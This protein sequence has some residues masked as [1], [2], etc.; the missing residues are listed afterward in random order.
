MEGS[1]QAQ[2]EEALLLR[3]LTELAGRAG[4]R[5]CFLFTEFLGLPEQAALHIAEKNF[6]GG[7][8]YRLFGGADGCE[9]QMARFGDPEELGYEEDFPITLLKISPKEEK[10]AEA[11]T[12]RDYLGALMN[13]GI[14]RDR[15][16]DIVIRGKTAYLFCTEEIAPHLAESLS[17]VRRTDV[18]CSVADSLPEG[19][20]YRTKPVTVQLSGERID[21]VVAKVFSLSRE[22]AQALFKRGLVFS[23]GR[24]VSNDSAAPKPGAVISVRGYGRM[25]YRGIASLSRKGKLNVLVEVYV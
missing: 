17:K 10:F 6:P 20:L 2:K 9:R 5:G 22:A 1:A 7:A 8:K 24:A 4:E 16:G 23:D 12:H 18:V 11:L 15:L 13:L 14:E 3:R 19:E 21:A 25:I